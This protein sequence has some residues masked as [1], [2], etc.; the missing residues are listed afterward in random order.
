MMG[1]PISDVDFFGT[2]RLVKEKEALGGA[3]SI[4]FVF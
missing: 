3:S 1:N 2:A 4:A